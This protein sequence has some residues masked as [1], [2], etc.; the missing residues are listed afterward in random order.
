[1]MF[2]QNSV[3]ST[4]LWKTRSNLSKFSR[5]VKKDPL[6]RADLFRFELNLPLSAQRTLPAFWSV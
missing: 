5:Q 4:Q 1:M 6:I 2:Q 3:K